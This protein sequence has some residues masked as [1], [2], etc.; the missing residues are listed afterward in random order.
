MEKKE[1]VKKEEPKK[2]EHKKE[3]DIKSEADRVDKALP[4]VD[5]KE[6]EKAALKTIDMS[7]LFIKKVQ[8]ELPTSADKKS[9][10]W[11]VAEDKS[12]NMKDKYNLA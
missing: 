5:Q 1:V 10:D 2:V 9:S 11:Q 8:S 4:G 7:S 6:I 3:S 12:K